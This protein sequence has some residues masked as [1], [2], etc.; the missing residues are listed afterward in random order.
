MNVAEEEV[1]NTH[2]DEQVAVIG[3]GIAG[4]LVAYELAGSGYQVSI[5]EERDTAFSGT[6]MGAL[7][8]HLGG[9]Y[10]GSSETAKE[11]LRS[12]IELKRTLPFALNAHKAMFLVADNSEVSLDGYL[13]FYTDLTEYY[14]S[15]PRTDQVFG[16]PEEFFTFKD[17]DDCKFIKNIQGGIETQEPGLDVR[18]TRRRL[19][20]KLACQGVK[21]ITGTEVMGASLGQRGFKLAFKNNGQGYSAHFDQVINAGGYKSRLLDHEFGDRTEYRL[22]LEAK[23]IVKNRNDTIPLPPFYVVRGY[24]MHVT[25]LGSSEYT[26]LITA[27]ED[28]SYIGTTT[29]DADNPTLPEDWQHMLMSGEVLDGAKRQKAMIDYA[30]SE[31]QLNA[32]F[33]STMLQPG[34]STW[35]SD[36]RQN[37]SQRGA[38]EVIPGWQSIIPTK[39]TNALALAKEAL[40]NSLNYSANR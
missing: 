39:F 26:S 24:F 29:Y 18:I 3:S 13:Q 22:S 35:Y 7:Q 15:L 38:N 23:N 36:S 5:F 34:I 21:V 30:Q 6:S 16:P 4:C 31:F 12:T 40:S 37:R 28:G 14:S 32:D 20:G 19:L 33:V 25:P 10:S 11:C 1:T 9:L 17:A 2:K 27:R 8:A